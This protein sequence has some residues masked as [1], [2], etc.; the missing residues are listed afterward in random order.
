MKKQTLP[1][2]KLPVAMHRQLAI[3]HVASTIGKLL[4]ANARSFVNGK[5]LMA[6]T[7]GSV[8]AFIS[9]FKFHIFYLS[10]GELINKLLQ[11]QRAPKRVNSQWSMANRATQ[12]SV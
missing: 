3:S 12:G 7:E 6:A 5:W 4:I 9:Y 2:T 11:A 8:S 1:I 10:W